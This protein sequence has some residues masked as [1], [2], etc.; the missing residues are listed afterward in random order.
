MNYSM[1]LKSTTHLDKRMNVRGISKAMI[2]F[3]VSYGEL[4]ADKLVVNKK[5]VRQMVEAINVEAIKLNRLRKKFEQFAVIRVIDKALNKLREQKKIALKVVAKGGIVVVVA[6][7]IVITTYDL[8][9][10]KKY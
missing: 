5:L 6:N 3:A 10:Y 9:S 7:N 2:E 1:N 8:D 4:H